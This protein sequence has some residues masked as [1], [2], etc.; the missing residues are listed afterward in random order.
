MKG[1]YEEFQRSATELLWIGVGIQ[2]S[3]FLNRLPACTWILEIAFVWEVGSFYVCLSI[4]VTAPRLLKT[5]H[6]K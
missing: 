1:Y 6:G 5:I 4:C 2:L 3:N